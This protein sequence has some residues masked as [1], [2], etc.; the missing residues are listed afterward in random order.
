M[1]R[2]LGL[3]SPHLKGA[4]VTTLQKA[5]KQNAFDHDFMPEAKVD[6]EFGQW[7]AQGCYRAQYWLGYAKPSHQAGTPLVAYLDG[8]KALSQPMRDQRKARIAHAAANQPLRV[9]AFKEALTHVGLKESPAGSNMQ[10]F[11]AWFGWNGVPWCAEFVSY[12]YAAAG[13]KNIA[14]RSRWAY[15]P[16]MVNAARSGSNGM[17]VTRDPK[18]GDIVL[19]DWDNDGV[20]NHVGLFDEWVT[21]GKTFKS[22]EANTSP[23]NASNGGAVV[24][25]GT[26]GFRPRSTSDVICF[27][28]LA[29]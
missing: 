16:Y 15:T 9:K 8:K 18:Q 14:K 17:T 3:T 26:A 28:H 4:D 6:G 10:M 22:L 2:V 1:A 24:H 25:Y 12:C 11:G 19:F 27:A 21:K 13:S 7:T 23:T 29:N 20:A 5:L